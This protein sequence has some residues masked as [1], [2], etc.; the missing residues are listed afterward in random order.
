[1]PVDENCLRFL[2]FISCISGISLTALHLKCLTVTT[3]SYVEIYQYSQISQNSKLEKQSLKTQNEPKIENVGF[4]SP[5]L[6]AAKMLFQFL[7]KYMINYTNNVKD[8]K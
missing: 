7:M 3:C 8:S 6:K 4:S 1:L 2:H 5:K